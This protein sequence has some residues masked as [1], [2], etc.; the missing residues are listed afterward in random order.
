M[1]TLF[2]QHF[3]TFFYKTFT[4]LPQLRVKSAVH[5]YVS[6]NNKSIETTKYSLLKK[7]PI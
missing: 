7:L 3:P 6:L 2:G 1:Q 5:L 4:N